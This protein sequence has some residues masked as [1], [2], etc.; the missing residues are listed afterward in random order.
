[1][2]V[3]FIVRY[4]RMMRREYL[5]VFPQRAKRCAKLTLS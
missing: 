3:I 5:K 4:I 1:M 2:V